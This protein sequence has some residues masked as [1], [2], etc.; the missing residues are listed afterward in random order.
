M[1]GTKLQ[2]EVMA[3]EAVTRPLKPI[4]PEATTRPLRP[5]DPSDATTDTLASRV[6]DPLDGTP[7][8]TVAPLG[9]GGMGEVVLAEHRNLGHVVAVKLVRLDHGD[10]ESRPEAIHPQLIERARI[11]AQ[12]GARIRH[13][14]LVAVH[15]FDTT[16]AGRPYL[17]MEYL[18]GQTLQSRLVHAGG[19]P[20]PLLESIELVIQI[21]RGLSAVHRAGLVHRDLKPS[22]VFL[23]APS[24]EE[25]AAGKRKSTVKVLDLGLAKVVELTTAAT[26][27]PLK[28]PTKAGVVLGTPRYMAPEQVG[29]S[30][31]VDARA[32]LYAV[33]LIL[34]RM[35]CGRG[36]FDKARTYED[37]LR[38]QAIEEPEPPSAHLTS[39]AGRPPL[40]AA[41]D[42]LVL[43][44]LAKRPGDRP[45]SAEMLADALS[46][47][48]EDARAG[49]LFSPDF[50]TQP[51][52]PATSMS[53]RSCAR[54]TA[55]EAAR[56]EP[57]ASRFPAGTVML[58]VLAAVVFGVV[59]GVTVLAFG[60]GGGL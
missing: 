45:E 54:P 53:D 42:A 51:M 21:L 11:E 15:G 59:V 6:L 55:I 40:P 28:F 8:R 1:A 20:L 41:L 36:P 33:G 7:Y 19:G 38:A 5:L 26:P 30:G 57:A 34:Y 32:D 49:D 18:D 44:C 60:G 4:S 12:A 48:A 27:D 22:N 25:V 46:R 29:A 17:V 24:K 47:I 16:P 35:L 9:E 31:Q 39:S 2:T 50:I 52:E 56:V 3:A 14:N 10:E 58:V 23:A 43:Q 37:V 13:E